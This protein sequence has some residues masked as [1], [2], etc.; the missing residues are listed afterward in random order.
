MSA[1]DLLV[2]LGKKI[3]QRIIEDT[4]PGD[5][6]LLS[7]IDPATFDKLKEETGDLQQVENALKST[8]RDYTAFQMIIPQYRQ[9]HC[10][11]I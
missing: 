2:A 8:G 10:R 11:Y 9:L 7:L 3:F 6:F 1:H 5:E 4:N